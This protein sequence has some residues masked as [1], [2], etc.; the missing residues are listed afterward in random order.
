M[1]LKQE[2]QKVMIGYKK[3]AHLDKKKKLIIKTTQN[4]CEK[5]QGRDKKPR[6]EQKHNIL[7]RLSLYYVSERDQF[8]MKL[9]FL[10]T[11]SPLSS[12]NIYMGSCPRI[13]TSYSFYTLRNMAEYKDK[14]PVIIFSLLRSFHSC[15]IIYRLRDKNAP[16]WHQDSKVG[17]FATVW[18]TSLSYQEGH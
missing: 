17:S 13:S 11:N 8:T 15:D 18:E 3:D 10:P 12:Q 6:F 9:L 4:V 2:I 16:T 14:C 7:A 1:A 5:P